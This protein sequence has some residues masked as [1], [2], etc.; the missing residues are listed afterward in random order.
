VRLSAPPR[1]GGLEGVA[2]RGKL[3]NAGTVLRVRF[4]GGEP[5][6]QAR[7]LKAARAWLVEGVRLDIVAAARGEKPQIRI[8]FDEKDGSW[9]AVGNDSLTHHPSQPTMNLGWAR[10]DTAE[11]DFS[12]VVIH[13][14]GHALGLLHEHNH[15]EARI[16]WNKPAVEA[17]LSGDPNWWDQETI[18]YNVYE[19]YERSDVVT[20]DFDAASVMIYPIP[21]SWTL[22]GRSFTPSWKLSAGDAKMI[23]QL[24]G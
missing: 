14:F 13:E 7:V 15:P 11:K 3:W 2:Q 23:R 1:T 24:Y 9:S 4:L 6:L 18:E 22:D 21:A 16:R 10:L 5:Q 12:S 8:A 17:D 20:T 19:A